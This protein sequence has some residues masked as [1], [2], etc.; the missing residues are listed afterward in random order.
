[1]AIKNQFTVQGISQISCDFGIIQSGIAS[2]Q[3]NAYVKVENVQCTKST[4][5]ALVSFSGQSGNMKKCYDFT[6]DLSG[7]N[8]IAQAY[9]Y[10]KTLPE[11]AGAID[12]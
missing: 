3:F 11:F 5:T 4:A 10:L 7:K 12:C 2:L 6:P 9:D 1:M 8:F